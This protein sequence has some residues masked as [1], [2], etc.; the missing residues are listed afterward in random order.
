M[1]T[2]ISM[3]QPTS[4]VTC[5]QIH[6]VSGIPMK[7]LISLS[8]SSQEWFDGLPKRAQKEYLIN[9]PRSKFGTVLAAAPKKLAAAPKKLAL[10]PVPKL[11]DLWRPSGEFS[12]AAN[13]RARKSAL[14]EISKI[15]AENEKR[16][17]T[18]TSTRA[19]R[20]QFRTE[21]ALNDKTI[22]T[23]SKKLYATLG[24]SARDTHGKAL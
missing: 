3:Y 13:E 4:S 17:A 6:Y 19:V 8:A 7:V 22:A 18:N 12:D 2:V 23:L 5:P 11:R 16:K 14:D 15:K 10:L 24:P 21:N 20:S 1:K 9:N